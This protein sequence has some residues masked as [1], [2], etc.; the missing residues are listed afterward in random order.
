[1]KRAGLRPDLGL[2]LE[3]DIAGLEQRLEIGQD[4]RPAAG[5]S[6]DK[7]DALAL[8]DLVR[9][10]ELRRLAAAVR[11]VISR[12]DLDRAARVAFR[13]DL[14]LPLIPPADNQPFRRRGFENLAAV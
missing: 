13:L 3:R 11:V 8:F 6:F 7:L 5:H 9:D 12:L 4:L 2:A 1:M 10:G 14:R